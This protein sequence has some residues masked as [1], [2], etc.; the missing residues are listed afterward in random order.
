MC[1][2]VGFIDN[3]NNN[4]DYKSI[5]RN[6][7]DSINHRG[8][9]DSG[10]WFDPNFNLGLTHR[11]L[12]IIDLTN[13]A[14]QPMVSKSN[15]Y[16]LV[17]NGEIYNHYE[18]RKKLNNEGK[19]IYWKGSGDTETLFNA[20]I[21]WGIKKTLEEC[22]GMFSFA[23]WNAKKKIISIARDRF[24][25]KPLYYG[26]NHK[27]QKK[28]FL[29][30]SELKAFDS[31]K[32]F[33]NSINKEALSK[34]FKYGNVPAPLSIYSN[35]S[36]L[37]PGTIANISVENLKIEFEEYWSINQ[38][39]ISK[40]NSMNNI[41]ISEAADST[42]ILLKEV[43]SNQM[44]ADVNLG[45]FLS[46]G[47]DS[48]LIV[49]LMQSISNDPIKT[50][51]IGFNERKLNEAAF[52]KKIAEH[53]GTN[54]TELYVTKDNLLN[55]VP[56]IKN[57]YDEP[58][59]DSSQIPTYLISK[60][61]KEQVKVALSGDGGDEI[62][63][64]Y[65]RYIF[66]EKYWEV[67]SFFPISIRN[68]IYE[69]YKI[70]PIFLFELILNKILRMDIYNIESS[71]N[72]VFVILKSNNINQAYSNLISIFLKPSEIVNDI[73]NPS[74]DDIILS[75][76]FN[77]SELMMIE[78]SKNYLTNDILT[79]VDRASMSVSL[80]TRI[81]FLDHKIFEHAWSLPYHFKIKK[82]KGNYDNKHILKKILSKYLPK[83]LIKKKK[84]GFAIPLSTWLKKDLRDWSE[85][86]ID[87]K[88]IKNQGYLNHKLV[89]NM[90]SDFINGKK[91]YDNKIWA[92]LMFQSWLER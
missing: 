20:L 64:G 12:S 49:S 56:L 19:N 50:F 8:P 90:W 72:K 82:I 54:H 21:C 40:K 17:Y 25:E 61:A 46:G 63:G 55:T 87:E 70:I 23:F 16:V 15:D 2:F 69:I 44:I 34:Y 6:L 43:L 60:L 53:L 7:G 14:Y 37:K 31:L 29:F 88:K 26:F 47:I 52:S 41:S 13:N 32:E 86:L 65:N 77:S 59:A 1:G 4:L 36:K 58:F 42:E 79:K 80:E 83:E 74:M 9:D 51:S 71:L 18:I 3:S 85:D 76:D 62:F 48:S 33:D 57:I 78:D 22:H 81:P 30:A 84:M 39:I 45:A 89:K 75:D 24:G 38:S 27:N 5:L 92:I 11:R 66:I 35:I 91:I 73:N 10:I 67:I 28:T 68:I